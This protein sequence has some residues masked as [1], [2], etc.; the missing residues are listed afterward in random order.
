MQHANSQQRMIATRRVAIMGIFANLALMAAK[1]VVGFMAQS[2]ALL[3]DGANSAGDVFSSVM[4][5][6]GG[7]IAGK[8]KDDEHPFGHGKAEYIF[9]FVIALSLLL[10]AG[11]LFYSSLQRIFNGSH[12][13]F[14]YLA[15][16]WRV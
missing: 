7:Y 5:Y 11:T 13:S 16:G 10:V 12:A 15:V 4:T 2:Q 3:A 1:L 6:L 9:S 14:S 8:P